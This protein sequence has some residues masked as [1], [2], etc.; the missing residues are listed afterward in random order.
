MRGIWR[1]R[2]GLVAC[3]GSVAL[4]LAGMSA[5]SAAPRTIAGSPQAPDQLQANMMNEPLAVEAASGIRFSWVTRDPRNGESQSAY[6]VRLAASPGDLGSS[7]RTW[8]SG[9]VASTDPWGGYDGPALQD[10]TRYWW[11]VRTYDAQGHPGPWSA[12]A[13]FGTAL[14]S[15]WSA[16]PIWSQPRFSLSQWTNY[17]ITAAFT[18]NEN[19]ASI[20]FRS[21]GTGNGYLW[22]FRSDTDILK[23]HVEVNGTFTVLKEVP[24]PI[25]LKDGTTYDVTIQAFGSAIT[26]WLDGQ[27]VDVTTD[28]TFSG[29]L[30]GVRSGG[31]ENASFSSLAVTAQDGTVLWQSQDG[32]SAGDLTCVTP[33]TGEFTV[34]PSAFC[35]LSQSS[36]W[37]FLRGDVTIARKPILAATVYA[38]G[39]STEPALQ[40]VF[41]LSLNGSVLGVGPTRDPNA[42]TSSEYSA[43][44]VTR[45]LRPGANTFGALAYTTEDQAFQLELVVRYQDGTTQVWGTGPDWQAMDG[46]EVY[47]WAGSIGTQYYQ[48][49]VEDL[50]AEQYPFGFDTPAFKATGTGWAAAAVKPAITG[51]VP[52]QTA[53][54]RLV[55]HRPVKI[56]EIGPGHYLLDFGTTQV[57][58]LRLTLDGTAGQQVTIRDGEVLSSPTSVQYHLN[59]G[60]VYDDTWTLRNGRQTLQFWGYR[61]FRY[62]EVIGAPQPLTDAN[63]A[64]LALVYPDQP[65]LSSMTT[66]NPQLNEVWQF[67]KNTIEDLNADLYMD[68]PTR[69]RAANDEGDDYIHQQSQAAVDGDSSLALYS[70]QFA[71]AYMA[72]TPTSITEYRQLAPVAALA[73]YWQTGDDAALAG[74]YPQ[75]QEMLL[76]KY[77]GSDG[78]INMPITDLTGITVPGVPTTLVDWPVSEQDGF[79]FS[80]QNTVVSEFAYAAYVAMAKIATVL[81]YTSDA[82]SYEQIA[83]TMKAAIQADLYDP[84]TGAFRDGVGISHEAI[85]SSVYAVALGVASPAQ[86][87]TA[88]AYITKLG[89]ACSVYCAAYLLEALYDGGQPQAA[90]DLLTASDET[91]WLHMISL[92]A[93]STMEAWDPSLKSNLSYS[94]PWATGPAFVVPEYL[95]GV[96]AL[97][98]GWGSILIHPQPANLARGTL[99]MPTA[100][101]EV[102]VAFQQTGSQFIAT[103]SV[104]TTATAEVSLPGMSVGTQVWVNGRA[105]T[106][107]ADAGL[108]VV[109][110]GSGTYQVRVASAPPAGS[111]HRG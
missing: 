27:L 71:L 24:L 58:G 7:R 54:V 20:F 59:T 37:A 25:A 35:V 45:A 89:M 105:E 82:Q 51:L 28:S 5:A 12:P 91:S 26:T 75:L 60:N 94:H 10:A 52:T 96:S 8:D 33:G 6:E 30:V 38:T 101:G 57:G 62:V 9:A 78:L 103:I 19:A 3:L 36:G 13:E 67:T 40:Y 4:L 77:L 98:P 80:T 32:S 43:W 107:V 110:I 109:A 73:S 104:P 87:Q 102:S 99:R 76:T 49:P 72:A 11:T 18:I 46:G 39:E 55:A 100:R 48:A 1:G 21:D 85:Q 64:A 17:T 34:P 63:T 42:A 83:A 79:V 66:S 50:D 65:S 44:D 53:N 14:G 90:L 88:A 92:G 47:P 16:Q 41:R 95:F 61:V 111:A 23:V 97:T 108:A 106:A 2:R 29:G 15:A 81:G 70:L 69:E 22:Q 56:T 31:S 86:A 74:M 68:S 84:A 93:G